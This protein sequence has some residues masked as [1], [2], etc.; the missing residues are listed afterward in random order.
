MPPGVRA[1]ST[2]LAGG[3]APRDTP[4][5]DRTL[6]TQLVRA[7]LAQRDA[8]YVASVVPVLGRLMRLWFRSEVRG[9]DR[10][11]VE[12]G[13]LIVSNHSGGLMA[14]DVPIIASAFVEEFGA[15]RPFYVLAHDVLINNAA[16]AFFRRCGFLAANRDNADAVLS[17]GAVTIVFP[18]GDYDVARPTSK[19]NVIDFGGRT[20]YVRTALGNGVPIVP[21]VSIGG[22]EAQLHLSRGEL[23]ARLTGVASR[24]RFPYLPV[25]VGFPFGL[26]VGF[27]PNLPLPT[28]ITTQVLD[29]IDV[30]AEFGADP[31]IAEVDEVVRGRMQDALD[32]LKRQR[33]FPVLG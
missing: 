22:Q 28:K 30:E 19:A 24:F 15:H 17:S 21:V 20:G 18:G 14:M 8:A 16:G 13:A 7:D 33:R 11:P 32:E 26:S 2:V 12:G 23:V 31:D 25:S 27:P 4:A 3:T 9:M 6:Q 29:P 10:I 5:V 1:L